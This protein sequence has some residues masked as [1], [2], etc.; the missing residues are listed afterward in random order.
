MKALMIRR[1]PPG[2]V[3][4]RCL[5]PRRVGGAD[6]AQGQAYHVPELMVI[7][8]IC[9]CEYTAHGH[10]GVI[11][12]G[13][14]ENDNTIANLGKQAVVAADAGAD[15][16]A[17]SAMMDGQ[18]TAIRPAL[19]ATAIADRRSWRIRPSSPRRFMGRSA[20]RPAATE[21]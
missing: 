7:S 5:E 8:D 2:V 1:L 15:M 4:Q 3:R 11:D 16:I 21:G 20:L 14:V 13:G 18:V 10:C 9:F 19:D 6:D 12:G 17:P